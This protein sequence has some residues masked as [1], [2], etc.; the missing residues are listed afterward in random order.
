MSG[1][2][3]ELRPERI[4]E[5][6]QRLSTV[7]GEKVGEIVAVNRMAKMLSINALI[8]ASRAGEAGRGFAIVAE[9]FKRISAEIDVVA[10]GLER[11]VGADLNELTQIGGAILGHLRGQRLA[12]LA[13]NAIDIVDRNLYERTCDVR[14]WATD[15]AVVAC[16]AEP[17]P[18]SVAH[19]SRRLGVIL[20]AYT[21][22][23]DLW[24]CD[25]AGRVV[26]S[27]RPDT[28]PA[29]AGASVA[30]SEWFKAA[31]RTAS[32]DEF[33]A[34][35]VETVPA[36]GGAAVATYA[37]AIRA[38]GRADGKVL[39]VLGIHFDWRPQAKAVMDGVRLTPEERTRSRIMILDR[40]KRIIAA[41]DTR[42]ELQE[43][44]PVNTSGGPLGSYATDD[45]IVGYALTPGYETYKGLGW[46]GCVVQS[47]LAAPS[48]RDAASRSSHAT[49]ISARPV[50]A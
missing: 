46:Y 10:S 21:V 31:M 25:V 47:K 24:I 13:L 35:N 3:T 42:G 49:E 26:A 39:G 9:E 7:A 41:S 17:D 29:V 34:C 27:G 5:L 1:A 14:W 30:G 45:A 50:A 43:I 22:Y 8:A 11:E 18:A 48:A 19:A 40:D 12:D 44:M 16:L 2:G 32:G 4:M 28:Y 20:G 6:S 33:A 37:T 38:G 15:S 36:L 23:L